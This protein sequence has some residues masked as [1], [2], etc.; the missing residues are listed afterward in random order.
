VINSIDELVE[1]KGEKSCLGKGTYASVKEVYHKALD[2]KFALKEIDLEKFAGSESFN[3]RVH[4]F[5]NN[6]VRAGQTRD[7]AP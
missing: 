3:K 2:R 7:Q 5:S 6:I 4:I 1:I